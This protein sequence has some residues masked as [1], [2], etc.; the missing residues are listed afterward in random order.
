LKRLVIVLGLFVLG[1]SAQSQEPLLATSSPELIALKARYRA[2]RDRGIKARS[3]PIKIVKLRDLLRAADRS[4]SG[5]GNDSTIAR[6]SPSRAVF[7][8]SLVPVLL[9]FAQQVAKAE[10]AAIPR[11][12]LE[13]ITAARSRW[14]RA[15]R[16]VQISDLDSDKF[17]KWRDEVLEAVPDV[18]RL[19]RGAIGRTW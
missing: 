13:D 14:R 5:L 4:L 19:V 3:L 2:I 7:K 17:S 1:H 9:D 15:W 8:L 12:L 16:E 18:Q 11:E 10:H 6:D